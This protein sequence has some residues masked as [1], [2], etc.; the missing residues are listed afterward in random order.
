MKNCPV[1]QFVLNFLKLKNVF[2]LG[3]LALKS[4]FLEMLVGLEFAI[5][6]MCYAV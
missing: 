4:C 6:S 3:F 5:S 1:N 2:S